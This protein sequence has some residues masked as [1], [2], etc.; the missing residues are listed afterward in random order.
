MPQKS[1]SD[2]ANRAWNILR[3]ALLWARKGGVF[4]RRLMME[5][6]V[7][8]KFLKS[9][10]HN[11]RRDRL[12]YGERELSF[13]ETPIFH[14]KMH[15]PASMRFSIPCITPQVDFDYD[16]DDEVIR[17]DD[18]YQDGSVYES[19]DEMRRSF[20]LKSGDEEEY[21]D[22]YETCEE[23]I[24]AEEKGID[25]RAEEFIA[26]FRQQMRLQR[27]ISYLKCHETPKKGTS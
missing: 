7:V 8:P 3:L 12:H 15:R 5:L 23:K 14:V 24:P 20:L 10:G 11:S 1:G 9:L 13:D 6:R 16:F 17:E 19:Y 4:K 27:Q 18:I 2:V 25:M 21:E 22:E 26:K